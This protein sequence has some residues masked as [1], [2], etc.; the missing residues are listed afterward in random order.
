M[1]CRGILVD[2]GG[3]VGAVIEPVR[4]CMG[5]RLDPETAVDKAEGE[6]FEPS[7][8]LRRQVFEMA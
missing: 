6:G 1:G 5:K 2:F 7:D 4:C 8:D 3:L